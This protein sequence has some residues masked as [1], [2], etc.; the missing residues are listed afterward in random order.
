MKFRSTV[1][2]EL[3]FFLCLVLVF[4]P[5][6]NIQ[7][8]LDAHRILFEHQALAPCTS[9]PS[10]CSDFKTQAQAPSKIPSTK[11]ALSKRR[12]SAEQ[13]CA[14]TH[15]Y[16]TKYVVIKMIRSGRRV[17]V[18]TKLDLLFYIM[19]KMKSVMWYTI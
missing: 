15:P 7:S 11:R 10:M 4:P 13:A 9:K 5:F 6:Y 17:V 18:V 19:E 3:P 2:F 12:A 16:Y 8:S 1:K 14:R